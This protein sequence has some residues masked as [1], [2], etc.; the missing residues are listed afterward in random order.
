M[1]S[2]SPFPHP[3][4]RAFSGV[5]VE[6]RCLDEWKIVD[7]SNAI[8]AKVD[9]TRKYKD[10]KISSKWRAE[11]KEQF[12]E[13]DH[14]EAVLDYVFRELEW[15]E[16]LQNEYGFAIELDDRIVS[17]ATAVSETIRQTL[18]KQS[19]ELLDSFG[20]DIDYHPGSNK[21]VIDL[22]HPS[23]FPLIY[24]RTK[25][26]DRNDTSKVIVAE[27]DELIAKTKKGVE[28]FGISKNYQ[29]LPS[30]FKYDKLS[31]LFVIDSYINNLH[32]VKFKLLYTT[33]AE[34]FNLAIPG[35]NLVLSRYAS[36]ENYRIEI[37]RYSDVYTKEYHE[38]LEKLEEELEE[39]EDYDYDRVEEFMETRL[40][41]INDYSP[42]YVSDPETKRIDLRED[43]DNLK[44]IVKLANIELTPEN[45]VYPGGSWHVEGT[46]N[47]D[48]V[49]TVLY[50]YDIENITESTL[51]YRAAFEDPHYEQG[52]SIY[53]EHFFGI[54]DE[55]D[56]SK[57][58]GST[59]AETNK[60]VIFP[61][62]FQHHV[63]G[64]E[65]LDKSKKGH[66]KILCFF[67][68]DPY[69]EKIVSTSE[70]PP[71]QEEWWVD[72]DIK[73]LV[74]KTIRNS[75]DKGQMKLSE[76]KEIRELLMKERSQVSEDDSWLNAYL[77]KFSLCEH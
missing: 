62:S 60:L 23:L 24:G 57:E 64:F 36:E 61:N 1:T 21:Q 17:S 76:A 3:Y 69:N 5:G 46:I 35:L 51:S 56:M 18:I 2:N 7:I 75:I 16:K 9:W 14:I 12:G 41:Y 68:C 27:Y 28:D 19:T 70:V 48:I 50:Y 26:V 32:P 31:K 34:V 8:R 77:R 4:W 20:A 6:A 59:K 72:N 66:R 39:E 13:D 49:A 67:L 29:W 43:F 42:K 45:P 30:Q 71:Q 25:V 44:V 58:L 65:L 37:P 52:D 63:D 10:E 55:E 54:K 73:E 74:P 53:C 47:E 33:I 15:Y 11:I 38:K 40:D 22:V